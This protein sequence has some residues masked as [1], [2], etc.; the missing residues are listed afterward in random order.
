MLTIDQHNEL[1]RSKTIGFVAYPGVELIDLCGPLDVFTHAGWCRQLV[2]KVDAPVY[3]LEVFAPQ[4]G[5]VVTSTGLAIVAGHAIGTLDMDIDTLIVPGGPEIDEALRDPV[6]IDWLRAMA[7]RVRRVVSVCT[8]AFLLAASGLLDGRR[9][10]THWAYSQRLS[11]EYPAI[12]VEADQIFVRDGK[13]YTSGG[14]T[15]GID[16]ALA[17][18]E[19]DHGRD[20]ASRVARRMVMF[21]KR[22]GDQS[23]FSAF[24]TAEAVNRQD[25]GELQAWIVA[26]PG[27]DLSVEALAE[28]VAMSPRNFARLFQKETE[29]TPAK[30]V[31]QARLENAR[32][33][34]LQATAPI[35]A[36]AEQCGFGNTERMRRSFQRM[37]RV[38]PHDYRARF[39]STAVN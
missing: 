21:L 39:R 27:A 23:Q 4:P 14:I 26:N 16:L 20:I 25:I 7:P 22:P 28:R 24:L 9:V 37:L 17:L 10:T 6:L 12:K 2:G 30:F 3:R 33:K 1:G 18:V 29:T 31:E 38:S 35:E 19:E 8:G 32:R 34:L 15:A 11:R 5:P 13:V 36:I